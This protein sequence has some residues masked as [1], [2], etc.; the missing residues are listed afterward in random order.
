MPDPCCWSRV[1]AL[2]GVR[3]RVSPWTGVVMGVGL[4][5]MTGAGQ[6]AVGQET[7]PE[8]SM[9]QLTDEERAAVGASLDALLRRLGWF[10]PANSAMSVRLVDCLWTPGITGPPARLLIAGH[11]GDGDVSVLERLCYKGPSGFVVVDSPRKLRG[12]VSIESAEAALRYARLFTSPATVKCLRQ[13]WWCEVMPRSSATDELLFGR[14]FS[15]WVP[16][17]TARSGSFGI[18]SDADWRGSGLDAASVRDTGEEFVITRPLARLS[19]GKPRTD[20]VYLVEESVSCEGRLWRALRGRVSLPH[21][22]VFVPL[23]R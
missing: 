13:P 1:R 15:P 22:E 10:G 21:V 23:D 2:P 19:Y 16:E 9:P 3:G 7:G 4:A 20:R 11:V 8:D 12:L 14:E 5:F 17:E 18:L 6:S